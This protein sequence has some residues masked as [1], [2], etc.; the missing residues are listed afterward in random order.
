MSIVKHSAQNKIVTL[1]ALSLQAILPR[2]GDI[3]PFHN[4]REIEIAGKLSHI[5]VHGTH[6][7]TCAQMSPVVSRQ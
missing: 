6:E 7:V 4:P 2:S 3:F 1:L 5:S